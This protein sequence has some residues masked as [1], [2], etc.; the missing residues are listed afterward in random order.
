MLEDIF[1]CI[2]PL[3]DLFWLIALFIAIRYFPCILI[4][5]SS[6]GSLVHCDPPNPPR[7]PPSATLAKVVGL[8][9]L[10]LRLP[11]LSVVPRGT[12]HHC[13]ENVV[14]GLAVCGAVPLKIFVKTVPEPP[15]LSPAQ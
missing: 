4:F 2:V 11:Q 8:V 5:P 9:I 1:H 14:P 6:Y 12:S 7:Y 3:H 10:I 15:P 13:P